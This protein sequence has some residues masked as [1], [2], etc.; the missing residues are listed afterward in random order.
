MTKLFHRLQPSQ[1]FRI[2]V[3]AIAQL[4]NIPK[5]LIVRIECWKYII[6]VHR[7]DCGGQ[8]ISYRKLQQW[9]NASACQIQ[10]CSTWQQL[11]QLWIEIEIDYKQYNK[12][13]DD[14]SHSSLCKIWE[15]YW[16]R[17]WQDQESIVPEFSF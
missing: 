8:F 2:S 4:L 7:R 17:L 14:Q 11:R 10:K 3:K 9:Q 5:H 1:K 6:F 12:Q 16:D 15:Q 13:Y